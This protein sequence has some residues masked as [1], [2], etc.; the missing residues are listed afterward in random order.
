M[1][2][3]WWLNMNEAERRA[4]VAQAVED[5][6][7]ERYE[8]ALVSAGRSGSAWEDLTDDQRERIRQINVQHVLR[9]REFGESLRVRKV[10]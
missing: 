1:S 5:D 9:M 3:E 7:K 6:H 4:F 8:E 2:E 10:E